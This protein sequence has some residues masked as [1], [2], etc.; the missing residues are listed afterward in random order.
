MNKLLVAFIAGAFALISAS[1][2]AQYAPDNT[3]QPLSKMDT[4]PE[5]AAGRDAAAKWAR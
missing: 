2:F 5:K 4:E 1:A 3:M